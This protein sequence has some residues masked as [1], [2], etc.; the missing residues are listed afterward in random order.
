MGYYTVR[1]REIQK[2]LGKKGY[3]MSKMLG[4]SY[5]WY[6]TVLSKGSDVFWVRAFVE[7]YDIKKVDSVN[8]IR[9]YNKLGDFLTSYKKGED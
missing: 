9:F 4:V 1:L 6:R 8:L 7:G 5:G 3:E 2:E